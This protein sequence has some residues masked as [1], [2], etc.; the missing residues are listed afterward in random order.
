MK[1]GRK[2]MRLW[3]KIVIIISVI[4]LLLAAAAY[5]AGVYYFSSHFLPGSVINGLNCSY[6]TVEE[7]QDLIADEIA[8]YTLTLHE[9]DGKDEKLVAADVGLTYVPDDTV[10]G[11]MESQA[12]WKWFLALKD[13]KKYHMS[14]NTTYNT[15]KLEKAVKAL[16]CFQ[17]A[18]VTEP[19]D[20]Y[21]RD[22][23]G[24][25]E[26]VPEVEGNKV[27]ARRLTRLVRK[28][29]EKGETEIDLVATGCYYKPKIYRDDEALN[30]EVEELNKLLGVIITYDFGDR[31]ETVNAS[32]IK[33]W[34]VKGE[35]GSYTLDQAKVADYVYQLGYQYDT[36]GLDH[37]FTTSEGA[38]ITVPGGDYGWA[39]AQGDET[40]ALID[41][42]MSGESQV[43]EPIY[44]YTAKSRY[45]N[46]IGDTYVE[47][48]LSE[49]R[50]WFYCDGALLVDTPIVTGNHSKGWDTPRGIYAIDAK[51]SPAILKGEGYASPVTY[52][53]PF[54]G[55]VGIHDAD[56]W[57]TEYG[58]DIYMTSGSHG[59]VNT[60]SANAE[61]I[62]NNIEIGDPVIVY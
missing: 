10:P 22:N 27:S 23:A 21:M 25:Y 48:S 12:K 37:E 19:Q 62:Y 43:R 3:K 5:G 26:I 47:I 58:G 40:Q 2:K 15:K 42:I 36:F 57:R 1:T 9:M 20:A 55:N 7:A 45:S 31:T 46:D 54:N 13:R 28:A 14:A 30:R 29:V 34:L 18:N 4:L 17:P 24:L 35:D 50:M 56:N 44:A 38:V 11:L 53:M 61:I 51:K 60:P 39:I 59:C 41:A 16:D 52:W 6:L 32:R 33:E 8:T 49:Q